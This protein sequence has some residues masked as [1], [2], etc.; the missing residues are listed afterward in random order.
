[1]P[2]FVREYWHFRDNFSA[3]VDESIPHV[4]S[5]AHLPFASATFNSNHE[6]RIAVNQQDLCVVPSQSGLHIAGR[7]TKADGTPAQATELVN[8][9]ICFLFE[10]L[11]TVSKSTDVATS[12]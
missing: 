8:N 4:E 10:E 1:M 11:R 3:G 6:I 12:V 7:L 9:A 2:R 5:H